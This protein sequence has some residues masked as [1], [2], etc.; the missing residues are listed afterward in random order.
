MEDQGYQAMENN[1]YQDNKSAIL[2]ENIGKSSSIKRT[3]HINIYLF[4]IPVYI[5]EKELNIEWCPPNGMI[6]NFITKPIKGSIFKKFRDL[7][8][9]VIQIKKYIKET[10]EC[11]IKKDIIW[12]FSP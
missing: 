4:F 12:I 3:K 9:G 8:M 11:K 5:S 1:V 2:L 10:K 6:G 7:I